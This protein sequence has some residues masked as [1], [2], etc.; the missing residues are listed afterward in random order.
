MIHHHVLFWLKN[1]GSREDRD[2]LIAGLE[3][4][5]PIPVIR[6]FAIGVPAATESRDVVESSYDASELMLFDS[7]E[8]QRR[9]QEHPLHVAF[10]AACSHLWN[11]VIVYDVEN[12]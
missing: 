1:S 11:K 3:T 4:L 7:I 5:R 2:A 10:V 12:L 9:Y 6:S 8:D